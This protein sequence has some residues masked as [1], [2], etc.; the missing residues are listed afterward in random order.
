[1][2]PENDFDIITINYHQTNGKPDKRFS[3]LPTVLQ[4]V[5]PMLEKTVVDLGCGSGFFTN[6]IAT[7]G[8]RRVIGIDTSEE[9]LRI[10]RANAAPNT[11]FS[12]GD[13]FTDKLPVAEVVVA[14][15]VANYARSTEEL[16]TF[17]RNV[18]RSCVAGGHAVFVVDMP[19]AS[20]NIEF[21]R[22]RA[23]GAVKF[24]CNGSPH[25]DGALIR[26]DLYNEHG[27]RTCSLWAHYYTQATL[28][29]ALQDAGF[30]DIRWHKPEISPE[31]L[32]K[33]GD[34]F[35]KNYIDHPELGYIT[36]T[37]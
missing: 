3:I 21:G 9:Q 37:T 13:I 7:H 32:K 19:D 1:M 5:K 34:S 18:F 25:T 36:A 22:R 8:A 17:I 35:W 14:P 15:F 20:C 30:R 12:K 11:E 2:R 27:H 33:Y 26:N 10:A 29:F 4:L 16:R 23:I 6:A 31:G 28:Q 24:W